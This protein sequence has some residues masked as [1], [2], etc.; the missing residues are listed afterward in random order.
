[1]LF[2]SDKAL[3]V[4]EQILQGAPEACRWT[5]SLLHSLDGIHLEGDIE[6]ALD[7]HLKARQSREAQE[8]LAA[9]SDKRAPNWALTSQ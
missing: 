6:K 8:G 2:R 9:F 7:C 3:E 5:K 4:A 1:M